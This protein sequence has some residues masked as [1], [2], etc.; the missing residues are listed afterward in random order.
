VANE[1]LVQLGSK[2][3]ILNSSDGV[4]SK[5]TNAPFG[6]IIQEYEIDLTGVDDFTWNPSWDCT[7]TSLEN[8]DSEGNGFDGLGL[9]PPTVTISGKFIFFM[10]IVESLGSST[11]DAILQW[12]GTTTPLKLSGIGDFLLYSTQQKNIIVNTT[13]QLS[14]KTTSADTACRVEFFFGR[15]EL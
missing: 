15:I 3:E 6:D 2:L 14:I 10:K 7:S 4:Y 5:N 9:F 12:A 8:L 13:P 1:S 11:P